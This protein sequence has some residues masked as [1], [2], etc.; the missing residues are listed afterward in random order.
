MLSVCAQSV[1]FKTALL[2]LKMSGSF[3]DGVVTVG[4]VHIRGI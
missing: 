2:G 3:S 4:V 1:L